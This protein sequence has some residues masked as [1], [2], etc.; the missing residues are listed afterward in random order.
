MG[1][2]NFNDSGKSK[3]IADSANVLRAQC[4][5]FDRTIISGNS[6]PLV[7]KTFSCEKAG[8][9]ASSMF[10][11]SRGILHF[12]LK[13]LKFSLQDVGCPILNFT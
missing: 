10:R 7:W 8:H 5:Q 3:D 6:L 4:P 2:T 9:L 1:L 12:G 13:C 11:A